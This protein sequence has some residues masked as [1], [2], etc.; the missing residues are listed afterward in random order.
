MDT[1]TIL[2]KYVCPVLIV[3]LAI[4]LGFQNYSLARQNELKNSI[5]SLSLQNDSLLK[6]NKSLYNENM[7]LHSI[8]EQHIKLDVT[9]VSHKGGGVVVNNSMCK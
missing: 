7:H 4:C 9:G 6:E 3:S 5:K 2:L 8:H 1:R